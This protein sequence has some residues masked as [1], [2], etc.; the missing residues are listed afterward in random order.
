MGVLNVTPDSFSD[1][2]RFL[3][4]LNAVQH[5]LALIRDGADILDVGGES[6]RPGAEEVST[7]TELRRVIP[8]IEGIARAADTPISI[9]TTKAEVAREALAAGASI[10]NDITGLHADASLA[11]VAAD[12][13]APIVAMHI[14]GTPRTMQEHPSYADLIGEITDYLRQSIAIAQANG[15]PAEQVIVDPGIGFG[16][17][18]GH[19]LEIMARLGELRSL[20]RPILVG[21]SRKST[22]GK[23]TG[24]PAGERVFGTA[25]T[26]AICVANGASIVR[27]HDVAEMVDVVKMADAICG[28]TMQNE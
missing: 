22:I 17:S 25:A 10:V 8:V 3:Q 21:T 5:G 20:G 14:K 9:D 23:V 26:V 6:T 1:G 7:A 27:V 15:V 12:F 2:G 19:N 11:R 18:V 16:K 13:S 28:R 4:P 24:K